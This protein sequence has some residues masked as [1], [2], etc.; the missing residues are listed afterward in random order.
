[1]SEAGRIGIQIAGSTPPASLARIVTEAESLGY[2]EVW[3]AEDYFELGGMTSAAVALSAT[4]GVPVG[5]GVV[6]AVARHPAVT[7]MEFA[8]LAG[9]FPGRFMAGLGHGGTGWVGQMGL[10]P[11][12][13]VRSLREATV[14]I[15]RLLDGETVSDAGESFRFDGIRLRH[16]PTRRVPIYLGVH[17]PRSLALSGELA[18]GTLL[19]WFSSPGYVSWARGQIDEGRRRAG[20][21]DPHDLVALC[22]I[23]ISERDP[24][25]AR[26]ELA[27]WAGPQLLAMIGTPIVGASEVGPQL[28][29][30]VWSH[31]GDATPGDLPDAFLDEFVAAGDARRCRA[32]I[33][34]LLAAGA[35]RVVLVPNPAGLRS[36]ESMVEQIRSAAVLLRGPGAPTA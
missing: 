33:D 35:D 16:P 14:A 23:G 4:E 7:A 32:M 11:P 18:D 10:R 19:G 13:V 17:G 1:M 36:T 2:A 29:R 27:S 6:A 20:R 31:G 12:S 8:T 28:A 3:L 15:R 25:S 22:I 21:S 5:L 9:V 24:E 34:R 30:L 26:G